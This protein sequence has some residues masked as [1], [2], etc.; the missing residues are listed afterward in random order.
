M[1]CTTGKHFQIEIIF[2]IKNPRK[3]KIGL[4]ISLFL[5]R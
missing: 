4:K 1:T 2:G 5:V 3:T